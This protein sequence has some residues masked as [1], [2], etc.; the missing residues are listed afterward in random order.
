MCIEYFSSM[1]CYLLPYL[2]Q[3]LK[4]SMLAKLPQELFQSKFNRTNVLIQEVSFNGFYYLRQ[5]TR[6]FAEIFFCHRTS[7]DTLQC[8]ADNIFMITD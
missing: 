8:E 4:L 1:M 6:D 5:L 2:V 7:S 3:A